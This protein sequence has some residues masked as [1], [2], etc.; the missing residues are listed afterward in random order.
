MVDARE[1][2]VF[3]LRGPLV[4]AFGLAARTQKNRAVFTA[5]EKTRKAVA[6]SLS[7]FSPNPVG[8]GFLD[9]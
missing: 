9:R 5:R 8:P 3:R 7:G 1:H 2:L 6:L 4:F